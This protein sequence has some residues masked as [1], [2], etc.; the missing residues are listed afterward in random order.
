MD[1]VQDV[2][3]IECL[4]GHGYRK[5]HPIKLVS[6]LIEYR[7]VRISPLLPEL[8]TSWEIL[9]I[10]PRPLQGQREGKGGKG[11]SDLVFC[12]SEFY[13]PWSLPWGGVQGACLSTCS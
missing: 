11:S 13:G 2:P 5:R 8:Y 6:V 7:C 1:T 12:T 9:K 10:R 3:L 4:A